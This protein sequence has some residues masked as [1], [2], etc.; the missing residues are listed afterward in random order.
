[1]LINNILP[2]HTKD[3]FRCGLITFDVGVSTTRQHL[4]TKSSGAQNKLRTW[5]FCL[6][7]TALK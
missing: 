4:T 1:M 6:Y 7:H 3:D 2:S 5:S